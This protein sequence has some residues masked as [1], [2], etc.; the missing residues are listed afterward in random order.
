MSD[1]KEDLIV[2]SQN[3]NIFVKIFETTFDMGKQI[4]KW[5][6]DNVTKVIAVFSALMVVVGS[7]IKFFHYCF[8]LGKSYYWG[9]SSNYINIEGENGLWG[10]LFYFAIAIVIVLSN[11]IAYEMYKRR[12]QITYLIGFTVFVLIIFLTISF[13]TISNLFSLLI[14]AGWQGLGYFCWFIFFSM[15][16]S[17]AINILAII[18][19][20]CSPKSIKKL[21]LERKICKIERKSD[22]KAKKVSD[23]IKS[24]EEKIKNIKKKIWIIRKCVIIFDNI[25]SRLERKKVKIETSRDKKIKKVSDKIKNDEELMKKSKNGIGLFTKDGISAFLIAS[26]ITLVISTFFFTYMGWGMGKSKTSITIIKEPT[27]ISNYQNF[28]SDDSLDKMEV[29][30]FESKE[31]FIVSPCEKTGEGKIIIYSDIQKVISK[32]NILT[33]KIKI[34][35]IERGKTMN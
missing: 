8:E 31:I 10:I 23:K 3:T 29:V 35:E 22:K 6:K 5:D 18:F 17:F 19:S 24:Y 12:R 30:I 16:F 21:R 28:E 27:F 2:E 26:I 15:I 9:Y 4:I 1:K 13:F 20:W 14:M 32:E 34:E 25:K 7:I 33:E 11:L